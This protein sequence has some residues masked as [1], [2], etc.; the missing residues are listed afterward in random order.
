MLRFIMEDELI[1]KIGEAVM[2]EVEEIEDI[3]YADGQTIILIGEN[4]KNYTLT[5]SEIKGKSRNR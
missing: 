2:L 1:F 5:L 3:E 4:K